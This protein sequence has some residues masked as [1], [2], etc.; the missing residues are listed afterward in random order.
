MPGRGEVLPA[1]GCAALAEGLQRTPLYEAHVRL[2]ARMV[3]FGG[4]EMPVQYP[5][6]ILAEHRAVR[7]AAGVFDVSHMGEFHFRGP[8]A[9]AL[10]QQLLTHDVASLADGQVLYA[11]M[12]YED[13]GTVDDCTLYRLAADHFML[14][15]NAANIAKDLAWVTEQARR[16]GAADVAIEDRSAETGLLALQGPRAQELLQPLTPVDLAAIGY[17]R[18]HSG[19]AVAGV[20]CLVARTGYTGEDGF[21][22]Y[23]AAAATPTLWEALLARGAVPCGLGARDTLRLE[24]ALNLYGHELSP[25]INP[26]EARM[27][28]FVKLDKGPF[29]GREALLRVRAAGGPARRLCGLELD[30]RNI[31]RAGMAVLHGGEVVGTVTSGTLSP[32]LQ[33]PIALAL[34]RAELAKVGTVLQVDIRG[35]AA[36]ARCVKLP[37]YRRAPATGP[38]GGVATV[39]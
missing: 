1:K 32:T 11:A 25:E 5:A 4:F 26:L 37:F 29:I 19:V 35:R 10:L 8:G 17:F 9:E 36:E 6:G 38:T 2:G 18:F 30:D 3:P 39:S 23:C 12:C 22:L 28:P 33:R 13:G 7:T 15:V 27:G 20:D 34:V 24:A 14:V 31:P 16:L 21:E